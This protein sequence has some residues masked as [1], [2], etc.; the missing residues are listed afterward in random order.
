MIRAK[1]GGEG[2]GTELRR[3]YL[4]VDASLRDRLE[5]QPPGKALAAHQPGAHS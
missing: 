4:V 5:A 3:Y 2:L 1:L